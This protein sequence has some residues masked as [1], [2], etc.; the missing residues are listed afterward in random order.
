MTSE[1][2]IAVR[3]YLVVQVFGLAALPLCLRLFHHLPDHGY[4]VSKPL[5]LLAAG[6]AFWLFV[7]FGWL[8]NTP[9]AILV[10]LVLLGVA[11][12]LFATQSSTSSLLSPHSGPSWRSIVVTE[13]VCALSFATW[14]VVRAHMPRIETAGGEKWME[15]AFLRAILRSGTFPPHDPWLSGFAISYYYFGYV[16]I[17]MLTKLAAAP[18]A[19]AFNLGV[20]T[21][22]ALT[23]TGAFSLVYNLLASATGRE[24]LFAP[25]PPSRRTEGA[26]SGG[27]LLGSLLGPLLVAVM[28]NLEGLME[29]LHARGIAPEPFW[30]WLDIRNINGPPP[31]FTEGSWVPSRFFWWWQASRVVRDLTLVGD[32]QEVIDEFPA[33]SFILAD[34]HPHVLALPFVLLSIALAL[35][36]YLGVMRNESQ[37]HACQPTESRYRLAWP[38]P[39]GAPEVLVYSLCLGGLG[40]LNT[41]DFPIYLF[42][43]VGAYGLGLLGSARHS[44]RDCLRRATLLLAVCLVVG[45]LLYLPFWVSFQSQAGG[46]LPNLFNP[47]RV[48]QFLIMFGPLIFL[49][50]LFG[51][52]QA[53]EAGV[54]ALDV[55]KWTLI[56]AATSVASLALVLGVLVALAWMGLLPAQGSAA[57][58]LAWLQGETIPGLESVAN[59]RAIISHRVMGRLSTPWTALGLTGLLVAIVLSITRGL[60]RRAADRMRAAPR[61]SQ[62]ASEVAVQ[63]FILLLLTTGVTLALSVEYL[64]LRDNFGTRM[65]TVFKFYFQAWVLWA[66]VGAYGLMSLVRRGRVAAVVVA[67]ILVMGGLVYPALAIPARAGEYG[68]PPTLDGIAYLAE[69]HPND[70]A[71]IV[72]LNQNVT[73]APVILEAPADRFG[74]YVYEGRISAHTGLPTVLG[75]AGHEHQWRGGY[76]EQ[77]RREGDIATLYAS[78]ALQAG[79]TATLLDEYGISY[80]YVGPLERARYPAAGLAKFSELMDVIYDTGTVTIYRR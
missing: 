77:A 56:A 7:T 19:I 47:T 24:R 22:F 57:Y 65:N 32:H 23:C 6:W 64:Y 18:P 21:L 59:A 5:G 37:D 29:V 55:V 17:A 36:L 10:V 50:S 69:T 51:V 66:L 35:N 30:K 61:S 63:P 31:A 48:Q 53:R 41:W 60:A 25:V 80:V 54:R 71:A 72:W 46:I 40:F 27:I 33:F 70:Y 49:G 2:L 11:G 79:G 4:G 76:E 28:G 45:V 62:R 68:G 58:L 74:A 26:T 67:A 1:I 20:P 12:L 3:W 8:A 44:A 39:L 73:G 52:D 38:G 43:V 78:E 16:I 13:T 42:I 34:L 75:W 15:T 9:G 14:C